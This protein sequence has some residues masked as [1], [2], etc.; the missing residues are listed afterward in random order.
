MAGRTKVAELLLG[1]GADVNAADDSKLTPLHYA[2]W[3]GH[4][5]LVKLLVARKANRSPKD[6]R[7]RTPLSLATERKNEAVVK[8]LEQSGTGK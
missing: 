2:A 5:E 8:V 6:E 7:G 1:R 4:V 3:G